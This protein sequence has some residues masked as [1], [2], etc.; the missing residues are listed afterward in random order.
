ML[1]DFIILYSL[2][3]IVIGEIYFR[4]SRHR[5]YP[6]DP[7]KYGAKRVVLRS[8]RKLN[9][10]SWY[11][12]NKGNKLAIVI[13][14]HFDNSAMM[15]DRYIPL[16]LTDGWNILAPDLRNHGQSDDDFPLTYGVRESI[17]IRLSINW[18]HRKRNW[19]KIIVFGTSMGSIAGLLAVYHTKHPIHGLILDSPFVST[20]NTFSLNI[21]KHKLPPKWFFKP[22]K[23][24]L[25]VRYRSKRYSFSHFPDIIQL[26][27]QVHERIP[28][29]VARGENDTEVA[30]EDFITLKKEIPGIT[31]LSV[32]KVHHS[33]LHESEKYRV[34]LKSWLDQL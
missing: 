10:N 5:A 8:P 23:W 4:V 22:L 18:A 32:P 17:D 14:G 20:D 19:D 24:Y 9:I 27:K 26:T 28:I 25:E 11:L 2:S 30:K 7:R 31:Y 29:F 21:Q 34:A 13:H 6:E 16:F 3:I 15:F 12:P 33:R 1:F